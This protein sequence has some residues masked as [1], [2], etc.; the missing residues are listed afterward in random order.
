MYRP[1]YGA[2]NDNHDIVNDSVRNYFGC[3]LFAELGEM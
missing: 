1:Q 2:A 3:L